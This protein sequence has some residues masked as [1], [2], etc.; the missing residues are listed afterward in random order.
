MPT[1]KEDLLRM[2][3]PPLISVVLVLAFFAIFDRWTKYH[4]PINSIVTIV[5]ALAGFGIGAGL[6]QLRVNRARRAAAGS[7]TASTS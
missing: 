4:D 1:S 3:V 7:S 5:L 2:A 6:D